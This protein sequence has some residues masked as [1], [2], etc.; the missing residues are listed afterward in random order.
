MNRKDRRRALKS[1]G[2]FKKKNSLNPLSSER[3][4]WRTQNRLEGENKHR[5]MLEE[6][7]KEKY[8]R[9]ENSVALYEKR[10]KEEGHTDKEIELLLEIRAIEEVKHKDT[11]REDKKRVKELRK[12]VKK[13]I[14]SR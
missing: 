3:S 10:L 4:Q 7:E 5:Q 14:E 2:V 13:L 6:I 11:Y 9:I 12:E 8:E 1:M